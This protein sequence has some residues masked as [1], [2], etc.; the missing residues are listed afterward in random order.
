MAVALDEAVRFMDERMAHTDSLKHRF[1]DACTK[2]NIRFATTLDDPFSNNTGILSMRFPEV[3]AE[4]LLLLLDSFGIC[5]ST[6]SACDSKSVNI[7]HVLSAIGL[8]DT[9]ARS[10]IRFSFGHQNT[11]EEVDYAVDSLAKCIDMIRSVI[12][13]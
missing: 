5:V 10:T 2:N 11:F 13:V 7:S 9:D 4:S 12:T 1:V 6:G 8:S 3:E